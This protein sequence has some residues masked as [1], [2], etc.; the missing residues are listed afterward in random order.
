MVNDA[1]KVKQKMKDAERNPPG[2]PS[3]QYRCKFHYSLFCQNLGHKFATHKSCF[4][5]NKTKKEREEAKKEIIRLS[6]EQ[7]LKNAKELRKYKEVF[8]NSL[9]RLL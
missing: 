2:T 4:M 5:V 6:V 3:S 9:I 1:K 7:H 8:L